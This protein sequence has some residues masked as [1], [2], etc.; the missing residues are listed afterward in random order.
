MPADFHR[1]L[2]EALN[3]QPPRAA[4]PGVGRAAAVLL[5]VVA[6][7][8]PSLILTVRSDTLPSHQGQISFP[9]GA[10]DPSDES[11]EA[12][13]L[14]ETEEELGLRPSLVRV[15]GRLDDVETYVSGY[16]VTP[17]VGW[18]ERLPELTPNPAEVADVF[19]VPTRELTDEIRADP[20]FLYGGRS[21]PTEAWIYDGYVIWG[22]T[23][24]ILRL[25]LARLGACG[26]G[27]TPAPEEAAWPESS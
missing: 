16:V 7:P 14:R 12:A 13:A 4:A 5:P 22:A 19:T 8:E 1:R 25:F 15:L 6:R 18:L 27:R 26:L 24:R 11:P 3:A 23:A 9:G 10:M 20:G 17:V 21:Y 2:A